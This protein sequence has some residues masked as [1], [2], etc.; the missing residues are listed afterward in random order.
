M[1]TFGFTKLAK[2]FSLSLISLATLTGG[3]SRALA[4]QECTHIRV[5]VNGKGIPVP[6]IVTL[7]KSQG[8][9]P[10]TVAVNDSCFRLPKQL[11]E[12]TAIDVIFQ[13][14][15]ENIHLVGVE[16]VR[17]AEA[18]TVVLNETASKE[19]L[20]SLHGAAKEIC[21]VNFDPGDGDGTSMAQAGCRSPVKTASPSGAG[22]EHQK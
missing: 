8:G 14:N 15:G 21:I 12:A 2:C 1:K 17:F 11:V 6:R 18:W 4:A 19:L 16:R 3:V 7:V 13:A 9:T 22:Q 20:S 10:T 5:E